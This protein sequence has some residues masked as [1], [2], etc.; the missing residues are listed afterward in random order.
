VDPL[1]LRE[2]IR[3]RG[4]SIGLTRVGFAAADPLPHSEQLQRWVEQGMAGTMDHMVQT[5]GVRH[6]PRNL[7]PEARSAIVTAVSCAPGARD[8]AHPLS[9]GLIARYARGRDYHPLLRAL[10]AELARAVEQ[11]VGRPLCSRIAVDTSP[12][13]EREL[14][15]AA[16]LGFIGKNT[17]L[18]TPGVGSYTVLGA[19]LVDVDLPPD[20]PDRLR[21]CGSC[22]LCLDACPTGALSGPYQLDA[23]RCISC[24]TIETTGP[25]DAPIHSWPGVGPWVYGCDACQQTCPYNT[26]A[27][28][29][30]PA[31]PELVGPATLPLAD[32]LELRSGEYRRLVRGRALSRCSR[33]TLIRNAALVAGT[34]LRLGL[35]DEQ[36][37]Q[38]LAR[39]A[40][41]ADP[42]V[43]RAA[44]E[45]LVV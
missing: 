37:V 22:T 13:L 1:E 4:E 20:G 40:D 15:A 36:I 10:L 8:G 11:L 27:G 3:A 30:V 28:R 7:L 25:I 14:A 2:R 16:G 34:Q 19:L 38:A 5:A 23:R 26:H 24:L 17:L 35:E 12:L 21:R 29:R 43:R 33:L 18:V 44:R 6:R 31:H 42:G 9:L 39:L 41:H 45:A 32:L